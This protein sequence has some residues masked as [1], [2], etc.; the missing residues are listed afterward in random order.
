[1][2]MARRL[3]LSFIFLFVGCGVNTVKTYRMHFS[4][5]GKDLSLE[6]FQ[7]YVVVY[8]TLGTGYCFDEIK[9]PALRDK[10][11]SKRGGEVI[12]QYQVQPRFW[13]RSRL[14]GP[15]CGWRERE[16]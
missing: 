16:R 7:P 2:E 14:Q 15:Y 12:A 10:L 5:D 6:I 13:S 4:L 1:M 11:A 3:A 9:S 8:R